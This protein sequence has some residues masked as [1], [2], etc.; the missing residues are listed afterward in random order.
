MENSKMSLIFAKYQVHG[1]VPALPA[2]ALRHA[3]LDVQ[4]RGGP[5]DAPECVNSPILKFLY[6]TILNG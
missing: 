3:D 5:G 1:N 6:N 4:V 2:E